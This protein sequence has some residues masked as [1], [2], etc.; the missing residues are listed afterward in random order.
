MRIR[1]V[2]WY[3]SQEEKVSQEQR[4]LVRGVSDE[5]EK[6]FIKLTPECGWLRN[7]CCHRHRSQ[8]LRDTGT[9]R[10]ARIRH[11]CKETIVLSCHRCL[12]NT[13]VGKNEQYFN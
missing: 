4:I 1:N 11:Q 13:G 5:E 8:S 3:R 9:N 6:R 2:L 10:I 12:I 7:L